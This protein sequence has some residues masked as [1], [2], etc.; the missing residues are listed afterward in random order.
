MVQFSLSLRQMGRILAFDFGTKRIG[1]AVTDTLGMIANP[2]DTVDA[3]RTFEY[4]KSYLL[5][6]K[7]S[8]FVV[9]EPKRLNGQ[10][11]HSS[12][13]V[14]KFVADLKKHFPEIPVVMVDERFTSRMAS[15]TIL[16]SGIGK[17]KRRDKALVDKVS[18][19][20][21]LQSY[22]ENQDFLTGI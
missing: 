18:A 4:L 8:K 9:G 2:L 12:E 3:S 13:G 16:D 19:V 6:E 20:I 1:M 22:L 11:S 15:Q 21:I 5:K 14:R 17:M 7:V 10:D